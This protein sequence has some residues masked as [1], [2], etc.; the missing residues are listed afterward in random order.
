MK[1]VLSLLFWAYV[2]V[3]CALL[4]WVALL[5]W[6]IC[7]PFDPQRRVL[8]R[9]S[10]WWGYHY[11]RVCP[12]WSASFSGREHITNEAAMIVSNH[13]SLGDILLLYGLNRHFK[14]VSK[15]SIFKLPFIGWNMVLN[16]YVKLVRGDR[17]SIVQMLKDCQAHL[18]EGSSIL[19]FPEGTRSRSG[20]IKPFKPGSFTLA[21]KANVP[22]IPV[23]IDGTG[24]ALPK[25]GY[26]IGAGKRLH[27]TVRVLPPIP[28]EAFPDD[29]KTLSEQV[30]TQMKE[31]LVQIREKTP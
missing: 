27:F 14:W 6:L 5:I 16:R 12:Y 2:M 24:E 22:I 9:F 19:M 29:L 23:V 1:H 20:D 7:L 17:R 13:Q 3:S 15:S 8:H 26:L 10:C 18:D 4:F 31:T 25:S 21:R 11:V 30:R 28:P